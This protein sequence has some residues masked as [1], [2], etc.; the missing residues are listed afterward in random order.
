MRILQASLFFFFDN[1]QGSSHSVSLDGPARRRGLA[2]WTWAAVVL[3]LV[4]VALL[5]G[6]V[7][8]VRTPAYWTRHGYIIL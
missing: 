4:A 1:R 6:V 3:V 8:G 2:M 7:G 5:V